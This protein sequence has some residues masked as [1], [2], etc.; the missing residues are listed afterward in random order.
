M[1]EFTDI[2]KHI[3]HTDIHIV[4]RPKFKVTQFYATV[5]LSEQFFWKHSYFL[6]CLF[7]YSRSYTIYNDTRTH[8]ALVSSSSRWNATIE[9]SQ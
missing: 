2:L 9:A 7:M 6:N 3:T 5:D 1:H 4:Q 8:I